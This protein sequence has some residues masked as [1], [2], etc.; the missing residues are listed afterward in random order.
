MS[1]TTA[2]SSTN[3]YPHD[4]HRTIAQPEEIGHDAWHVSLSNS[5]LH[6]GQW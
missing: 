1:A 3:S 4:G 6:S 5:R 2:L